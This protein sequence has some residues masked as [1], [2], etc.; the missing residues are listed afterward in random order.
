MKKYIVTGGCG[1]IGSNF[2]RLLHENTDAEIVIIDKMTYAADI[3]N[4]PDGMWDRVELVTADLS[5]LFEFDHNPFDGNVEAIFHFAAESHVDNSIVGPGVFVDA[6]IKSTLN[7]LEIAKDQ[8]IKFIHISTDEVYGALGKDDPSFIETQMLA[9]N[10]TY[11]ATKTGA[12][13]LVRAYNK[14]HHVE[15]VVTRCCNNYGPRQHREKLLPKTI[16]NA[17]ERKTIPVYGTGENV[18]EWIHVDDHCSAIWHAAN[19]GES[20][21]V[22]NIGSGVEITNIEIVKQVLD[23]TDRPESLIKFVEDR[24]GHDFRYSINFDKMKS[25]GWMPKY[26]TMEMLL[27]HGLPETV[28]WYSNKYSCETV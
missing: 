13:M 6:N 1:F 14:T 8:G 27:N 26:G 17:L 4:I 9:P 18:R 19:H 21:E 12:E 23:I 20:G 16:S 22:Y 11:S 24:K 15:T 28:D 25:I 3:N 2:V 10:N 7:L 5:S